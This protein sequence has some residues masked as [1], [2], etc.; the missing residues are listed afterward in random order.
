MKP[1][2]RDFKQD[3]KLKF[4]YIEG[5]KGYGSDFIGVSPKGERGNW[6]VY[7]LFDLFM[8]TPINKSKNLMEELEKRGY[9]IETVYFEIEKKKE[10]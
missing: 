7:V 1:R 10:E 2:K 4:C 5:H 6:D 8:Q 3:D 9:D